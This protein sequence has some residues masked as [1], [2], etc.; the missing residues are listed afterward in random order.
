MLKNVVL[1]FLGLMSLVLVGQE[2]LAVAPLD[3]T[4][5]TFTLET[6]KNPLSYEQNEPINFRFIIELHGQK[7]QEELKVLYCLRDD[8]GKKEE[9]TLVYD[10]TAP[11]GV[12]TTLG[13]DGFVWLNAILADKQGNILKGGRFVCNGGACVHPERLQ[14]GAPEPDDFDEFWAR[15]KQRLAAVPLKYEMKEVQEFEH[16]KVY[17]VTIDCAGP[18]PCTGFLRLPKD[19]E[20]KQVPGQISF[21][22]YGFHTAS[23]AKQ[24]FGDTKEARLDFQVNAHGVELLRDEAYYKEFAES[25]K[26]NGKPY[27]F[28]PEQNSDPEQAYFNGMAMRLMRAVE[29]V[30][31]LPQLDP[32][33]LTVIG[34]SQGGMQSIWAAALCEGI[35]WAEVHIPWFCDQ[36]GQSKAGRMFGGWRIPYSPSLDYYDCVNMAKRVKC[37]VRIGLAGLGD[38]TCPPSGVAI[39]FNNLPVKKRIHWFQDATHGGPWNKKAFVID[40][41]G[42]EL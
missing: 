19:L 29:F 7:L 21:Q 17:V 4:N 13:Q 42:F 16:T 28:D 11:L 26:S 15:Q 8:A 38:Y 22:G 37:T 23:Y 18:R 6:D 32:Q 20:G 9:K 31:S 3:T 5:I 36:A 41:N 1:L 25:I 30:Q 14:Q 33:R 39:L 27:A 10:G 12:T 2:A 34:G 40:G 24:P 35:S